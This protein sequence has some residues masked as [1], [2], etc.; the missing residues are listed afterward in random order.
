M[1]SCCEH[2][3]EHSGSIKIEQFVVNLSDCHFLKIDSP[4]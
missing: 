3:N 4:P 2:G 1:A